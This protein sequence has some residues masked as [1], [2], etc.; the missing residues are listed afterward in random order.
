MLVAPVR[1]QLHARF[2]SARLGDGVDREM[3]AE[4]AR[5]QVL[6]P[7]IDV[8]DT[9]DRAREHGDLDEGFRAVAEQLER[10]VTGL[11]LTKFGA[12]GDFAQAYVLAHEIGHHIQ[13]VTGTEARVRQLQEQRPQL[14]NNLSVR[15]ELQA[16]CYAGVWGYFA[17]KRNLLESGDLEEGF[18]AASAVGDDS[19][20]K[21]SRG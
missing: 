20:Q 8:L 13:K 10:V 7:I 11:G 16:D 19:I 5:Y 14:K 12:P 9:V 2:R 6:V 15:L 18:R 4:N 21:K 3:L 17:Q 1:E